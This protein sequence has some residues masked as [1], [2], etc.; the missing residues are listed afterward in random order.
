MTRK[1][2]IGTPEA[3]S[4]PASPV[5]LEAPAQIADFWLQMMK[6]LPGVEK[7]LEGGKDML[8]VPVTAGVDEAMRMAE[9][10][11]SLVNTQMKAWTQW[12]SGMAQWML[13]A[14]PDQPAVNPDSAGPLLCPPED[15]T[16]ANLLK[17]ANGVMNAMAG[18][19]MT[20]VR[21]DVE[22]MAEQAAK[23]PQE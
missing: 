5:W 23:P 10:F 13:M 1:T 19:W 18:A 7:Q 20:A 8:S 11:N 17:T 6:P 14:S 22:D 16:P 3:V 21:H 2:P 9:L 12:Q 4:A 15:L